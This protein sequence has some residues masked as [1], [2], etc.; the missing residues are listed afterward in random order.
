MRMDNRH[1]LVEKY[2]KQAPRYTSYP[3]ALYFREL[4]D[5]S[6]AASHVRERN[7]VPRPV[8]LYIHIPFCASL[9][10]YC[11]CTKVISRRDGDSTAYLNR[12]YLEMEMLQS[13][14]HTDNTVAQIHFGGG[15]PT[16]LNPDELRE[17]G[18]RLRTQFKIDRHAE[19]SVEIDPRRFTAA[20]AS[21]LAEIGCNRASI[22][23]QDI[24]EEVQAAINR[25][26]P[27]TINEQVV[28]WLRDAGIHALNVDLI[29]GLPCQTVTSFEDTLEA[30]KV[31]DPDRFAIFNYAHLPSIMPAQK[32]LDRHP[33]PGAH[34]KFSMLLMMTRNLTGSGYSYI[35][36]DHFAKDGD[37]LSIAQR[38]GTLQ[39]NFQGYST[40]GDTDI[41][42]LGMSSISQI[43]NAYLQSVKD[44][45]EYQQR[46]DERSYPW[47]RYYI[48]THDDQVRRYCIMRL[49][50]DLKLDF[51]AVGE[52]WDI[53]GGSYFSSSVPMLNELSDDGLIEW[54][55]NGFRV[56]G[57]G[58]LFLRNIATTLDAYHA[59]PEKRAR[60]SK[61]V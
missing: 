9:C 15:T 57:P 16:F 49:M 18:N 48:L 50:C 47:H 45:D 4:P 58:R 27:M 17:L 46:V 12:L 33:M 59:D 3:S 7:A 38:N 2:S 35:G 32:L 42:G 54:E 44:L 24:Q 10:W 14:L 29:Y 25:I 6:L 61:T 39:R 41:Y 20:H 60:Y 26:Q 40:R 51:N 28:Q 8:S 30:V 23:I 56:T 19:F 5:A 55:P 34:E 52:K 31:L 11:G 53:D 37:E 1:E 36:M 13:M 43:G 22:G 21:A